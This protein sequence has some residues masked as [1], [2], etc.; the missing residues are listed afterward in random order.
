MKKDAEKVKSAGSSQYNPGWHEA[1]SLRSM[2]I[3][4][5]AVARAG[6]ERKESRGAHTRLDYFG[7]DKEWQKYNIVIRKGTDGRMEVEKVLRVSSSPELERI[8]NSSIEDL[9]I[10]VAKEKSDLKI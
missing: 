10:E 3:T 1:I 9:E 6:L 4:S 8:A 5:E 2:L 7:E